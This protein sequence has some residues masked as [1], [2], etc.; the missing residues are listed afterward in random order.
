MDTTRR[1]IGAFGVV[2][3]LGA[4]GAGPSTRLEVSGGTADQRQLLA[5]AVDR[6]EAAGLELP[7]LEF[8]FTDDRD[9]CAQHLGYYRD[10]TIWFCHEGTSDMAE[11]GIV[12][13]L[14]HSWIE[15]TL[16]TD[17]R[18]RFLELRGLSTW[19]DPG[20]SWDERGSEQSAE[21]LAWA[22][23]DQATGIRAPSF[24]EN[25]RPELAA[26]YRVLTGRSL[27]RLD[28]SE[29]WVPPAP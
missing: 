5:W 26:A 3:L 10:G 6:F 15:T 29:L 28:P 19:N 16:P 8:R 18:A 21:I 22:I 11:R 13:E 24:A 4:F 12:H 20:V 23:G 17:V 27:P 1:L 2:L 25:S 14:A 9:A 7:P